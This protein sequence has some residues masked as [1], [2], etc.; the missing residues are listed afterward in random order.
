MTISN[1]TRAERPEAALQTSVAVAHCEDGWPGI[2]DLITDLVHLAAKI[3]PETEDDPRDPLSVLEPPGC[4]LKPKPNTWRAQGRMDYD[5][6]ARRLFFPSCAARRRTWPNVPM[7]KRYNANAGSGR[8]VSPASS[9]KKM[10]T[11]PPLSTRSRRLFNSRP[12][13]D[14]PQTRPRRQRQRRAGI[15]STTIS[16]AVS[17]R[18]MTVQTWSP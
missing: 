15:A 7:P 5:P 9:S 8:Y 11:I 12:R 3:G 6:L 2:I 18:C 14:K 17:G 4:I 13:L 16:I 10:A 1:E